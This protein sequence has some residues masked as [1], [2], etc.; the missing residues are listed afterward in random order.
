MALAPSAPD[1]VVNRERPAKVITVG[2]NTRERGRLMHSVHAF[3]ASLLV[4]RVG[5]GDNSTCFTHFL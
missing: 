1:D 3:K 2:V 4:S 5:L